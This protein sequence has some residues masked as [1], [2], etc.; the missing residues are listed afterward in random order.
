[1]ESPFSSLEPGKAKSDLRDGPRPSPRL[2][3]GLIVQASWSEEG[4]P[5]LVPIRSMCWLGMEGRLPNKPFSQL[6]PRK[7]NV[8]GRVMALPFLNLALLLFLLCLKWD[9]TD[10]PPLELAL[11]SLG[12]LPPVFFQP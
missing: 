3:S 4:Q 5:L 8:E 7:L 6:G 10:S 12:S 9:Q 2:L 11:L 1:M